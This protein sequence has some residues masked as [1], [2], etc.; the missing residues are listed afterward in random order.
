[1]L[2]LTFLFFIFGTQSQAQYNVTYHYYTII[3]HKKIWQ[4]ILERN[5]ITTICLTH[6]DFMDNAWSLKQD[7]GTV[8]Q[9]TSL[10]YIKVNKFILGTSLSSLVLI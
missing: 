4:K 1:M 8:I 2:N 7:N 5:N 9:T 6:V 10:A 3:C